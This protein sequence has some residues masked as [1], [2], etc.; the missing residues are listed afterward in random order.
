MV[1]VSRQFVDNNTNIHVSGSHLILHQI[2]HT[3]MDPGVNS[4]A[5]LRSSGRHFI[6]FCT[7]SM[8]SLLSS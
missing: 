8:N 5:A 1:E 7:K 2:L 6:I 3:A 4:F